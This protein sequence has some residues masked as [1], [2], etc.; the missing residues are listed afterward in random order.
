MSLV[1]GLFVWAVL[2]LWFVLPRTGDWLSRLLTAVAWAP[3]LVSGLV[4][5][6]YFFLQQS[7]L[8]GAGPVRWALATLIVAGVGLAIW[9][10]RRLPGTRSHRSETPRRGSVVALVLFHLILAGTG[11]LL[12]DHIL[13]LT[14]VRPY[15]ATDAI[16]MWNGHARVLVRAEGDPRPTYR[17]L[18]HSHPDYPLHIKGAVVGVTLAVG[19]EHVRTAQVLHLLFL[20]GLTAG[21]YQC[22]AERTDNAVA[23]AATSVLLASPVVWSWSTAQC[24]DIPMAY[25]VLCSFW[26]LSGIFAGRW[27]IP[28]LL[29]GFGWGLL[30]WTKVEGVLLAGSL[31]L[32]LLVAG[33]V[34]RPKLERRPLTTL[35]AAAALPVLA[36]VL[37]KRDWTSGGGVVRRVLTEDLGDKIVDPSRWMLIV[38]SLADQV[39]P[40]RDHPIWGAFWLLAAAILIW[41]I[42]SRR[43]PAFAIAAA[44]LATTCLLSSYVVTPYPL[45]WQL[46][47]SLQ[48]VLLQL[49]PLWIVAAGLV[50]FETDRAGNG[51]IGEAV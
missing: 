43:G 33:W 40:L 28:P 32:A 8:Y 44:A 11:L 14:P 3:L 37:F 45:A 42:L 5:L 13:R 34:R 46:A 51:E 30:V 16:A 48:R 49:F 4:S 19:H 25:L 27:R 1:V 17:L 22:L 18:K 23:A 41:G 29:V 47:S 6:I 20:L 7:G 31:L 24:A 10:A 39:N 35:L 21:L 15:G 38:S 36:N 2:V 26:G 50:L 9:S 12:A